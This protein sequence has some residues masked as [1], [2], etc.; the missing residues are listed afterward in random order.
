MSILYMYK[1]VYIY[2][3]IHM[4]MYIQFSIPYTRDTSPINHSYVSQYQVG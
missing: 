1:D 4:Y 2:V 3:Y